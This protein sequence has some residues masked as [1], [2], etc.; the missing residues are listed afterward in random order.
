MAA[1]RFLGRKIG[2]RGVKD[3][4]IEAIKAASLDSG[5]C[6]LS[7]LEISAD[8]ET[9]HD[10]WR[11]VARLATETLYSLK[12]TLLEEKSTAWI[13]AVFGVRSEDLMPSDAYIQA[14]IFPLLD[15]DNALFEAAQSERVS[16]TPLL[17][18]RVSK[19]DSS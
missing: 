9:R 10:A 14:E 18:S 2:T 12:D 17:S 6:R 13:T 8:R 16:A 19:E 3:S 11:K 1:A 4:L 5:G 15:A 7:A